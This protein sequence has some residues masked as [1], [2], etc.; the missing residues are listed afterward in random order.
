MRTTLTIADDLAEQIE[1]IRRRQGLS[2][3]SVI[4]ALLRDGLEYRSRP[5]QA[6][7]FQTKTHALDLRPGFDATRLNQL[8][9]DLE[10]EVFSEKQARLR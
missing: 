3:K 9:D 5:L 4:N 6:K 7:P 2:L 8:A 1:A 10:A